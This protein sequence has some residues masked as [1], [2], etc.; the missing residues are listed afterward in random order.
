M[1]KARSYEAYAVF[2]RPG[3][4]GQPS[5][6]EAF[7]YVSNG[8]EDDPNFGALHRRLWSWGGVPLVYR[9]LVGVVQLF[10]CGHEPDFDS[11]TGEP[12]CK[13][14]AR[15]L[16]A[17]QISTDPWWDISRLQ[18]GSLWDDR[19]ACEKLLSQEKAV[20][21]SL[22]GAVKE[23]KEVLHEDPILPKHLARRLLILSLLIAYLEDR[24]IL[25]AGFF[26]KFLG[27]SD[28]RFFEVLSRGD[29]LVDMLLALKD[30][31][32][33]NVFHL[34]ARDQEQLR[35]STALN[36][37]AK[38]IEGR[39][40]RHGQRTL[41]RR[42]SF[43]D[44][45]VE[46]ISH[47]YQLF[48]KDAASS[49]YTPP[50]LVRLMLEESL[51][52][53]RV[54]HLEESGE[55]ILDP[56]C[57]SGIFLVE[58]YKRLILRWRSLNDWATP[59]ID[60]LHRLVNKVW[61]V[62]L[63][64]GAVELAAFSLCVALCDALDDQTLRNSSELFPELVGKTLHISCFFKA[65]RSGVLNVPVGVVVG[66]P[67]FRSSLQTPGE[68]S[69]RDDCVA[70]Y[71]ALPDL[72]VAYLFLREG[73]LTLQ[74]GGTLCLLQQYNL[75]YNPTSH[76]FRQAF[77]KDWDV[78]EVLDF[79]SVRG[80]F[81]K[82]DTKVIVL[83]ARAQKPDPG[84]VLHV[85]FR[86]TGRIKAEQGFDLDYYD[87]HWVPHDV[88]MTSDDVW[89]SDLFGGGRILALV[90]RLREVDTIGK[91]AGAR[92]WSC[93]EGWIGGGAGRGGA[94][95]HI[96]GKPL[97][98]SR[99][100]TEQGV[101]TMAIVKVPEML[102]EGPRDKKRFTPPMLLV[103]EHMDLPH[104]LWTGSYL[105]YK[106][107]IVG[108]CA[109]RKDLYELQALDRWLSAN[110]RTLKAFVA[111]V[112]GRLFTQKATALSQADILG[113]PYPED[114][115][116]DLSENE[117]VLVDDI[118]DHYR[119]LVRFGDESAA[120]APVKSKHLT[121]FASAYV[122]Q[123]NATYK[124]LRSLDPVTWP[125]I[126]CQPFVFGQG[127]VDWSNADE[128][129]GKLASLI[130]ERRGPSLEVTRVVR[131]YD[132]AF[133]FMLKPDRLRYW[134]RSVAL[135]DADETLDDLRRQGF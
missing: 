51:D 53:A 133:L 52:W 18:N 11:E 101:D 44:L 4:Q 118:V 125:G 120:V 84:P 113:L 39:E 57:G 112:S 30:W 19:E 88:A 21:R 107:K 121:A 61:G 62:D 82:A 64:R 75:F 76:V 71:G 98:P 46:L 24:E 65:R 80:L 126:V 105:T 56:C 42:Y 102:I 103:R 86:R 66:N 9:K 134:L 99:A 26:G 131:Y 69:A 123:I 109:P 132:G 29:A 49:V 100:L 34:G 114:G 47:V 115:N 27:K 68:K 17:T 50:F 28:G 94:A 95:A 73:A 72:Q 116:L 110:K 12:I 10:R 97:L 91:L 78:R 58:A 5:V 20:S 106:N 67:P 89:R 60:E 92:G 37:F 70:E 8:P 55:V 128:L 23:L 83:V 130:A 135:R 15:L 16:L 31:F 13:P 38:L 2:F 96:I 63:E 87:M 54:D 108:V 111:A 41:W 7:V 79:I 59:P 35:Q 25:D 81:G 14:V 93:G 124:T 85:T 127:K 33:G 122:R 117:Q 45:P 129:R 36:Q 22:I 74:P 43:K 32:N 104:V 77:F 48:V 40:E 6:A 119:D 3:A 90:E 1:E